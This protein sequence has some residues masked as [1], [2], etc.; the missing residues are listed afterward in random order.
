[1]L[2]INLTSFAGLKKTKLLITGDGSGP[3]SARSPP[4]NVLLVLNLDPFSLSLSL[5]FKN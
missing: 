1:M 5:S 4:A 3:A 2:G